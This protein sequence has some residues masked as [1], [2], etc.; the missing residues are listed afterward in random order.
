M[1]RITQY[2]G[3][4]SPTRSHCKLFSTIP[5]TATPQ[6]EAITNAS[7]RNFGIFKHPG[8]DGQTNLQSA[9]PD[10]SQRPTSS[11]GPKPAT[12]QSKYDGDCIEKMHGAGLLDVYWHGKC[13][14]EK[15]TTG[16][17]QVKGQGGMFA[18]VGT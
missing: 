15:V 13:D 17:Y 6:F 7:H 1:H 9:R 2:H 16:T 12:E 8:Q 10:A 14:A 18:L 4:S 5:R 11:R 3:V